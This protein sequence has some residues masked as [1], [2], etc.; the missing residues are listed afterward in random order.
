MQEFKYMAEMAAMEFELILARD[1]IDLDWTGF[2]DT[3]SVFVL[4]TLEIIQSLRNE[5]FKDVF[6]QVKARKMQA[7]RSH[8]LQQTFRLASSYIDT[9]LLDGDWEQK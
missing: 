5:D 2:S 8:Y 7:L 6:E 1:C 3:L 4:K 9:I